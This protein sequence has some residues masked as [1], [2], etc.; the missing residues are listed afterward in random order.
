MNGKQLA[1]RLVKTRPEIEVLFISG[2]AD[3]SLFSRDEQNGR[4]E[5]LEKP[6]SPLVLTRKVRELLDDRG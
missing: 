5:L 3:G 1:D 6:F 4:F 2:Y